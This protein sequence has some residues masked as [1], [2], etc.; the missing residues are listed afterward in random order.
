MRR[1]MVWLG[2]INGKMGVRCTKCL[3]LKDG[4]CFRTKIPLKEQDKQ[5]ICGLWK[6][7][8]VWLKR[9]SN[10]NTNKEDNLRLKDT[11]K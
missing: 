6:K 8:Y 7:R 1:S 2:Y 11:S 3:R 4:K 10:T 5:R 9:N